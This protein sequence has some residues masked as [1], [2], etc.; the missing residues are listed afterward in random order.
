MSVH[1]LL[2]WRAQKD[3]VSQSGRDSRELVLSLVPAWGGRGQEV[4]EPPVDWR[5]DCHPTPLPLPLHPMLPL[6]QCVLGTL[7]SLWGTGRAA[8]SLDSTFGGWWRWCLA[9]LS[10]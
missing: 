2:V 1:A 3:R 10:C 8:Q 9:C 4:A 7:L 6:T 5:R